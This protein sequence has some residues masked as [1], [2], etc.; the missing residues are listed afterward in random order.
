MCCSQAEGVHF[1]VWG[2]G[3]AIAV[4]SPHH[5]VSSPLQQQ[6]DQLKVSCRQTSKICIHRCSPLTVSC[7]YWVMFTVLDYLRRRLT[8]EVFLCSSPSHPAES[9]PRLPRHP[10]AT[11]RQKEREER[12]GKREDREIER[13]SDRVQNLITFNSFLQCDLDSKLKCL[14]DTFSAE[15]ERET[16][17]KHTEHP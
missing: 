12:R 13:Q 1:A 9:P 8:A 5:W 11:D 10:S 17:K 15:W 6:T 2:C 16:Q 7:P 4:H 3:D 14:Q